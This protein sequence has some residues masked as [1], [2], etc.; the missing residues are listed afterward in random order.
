MV[1]G[2]PPVGRLRVIRCEDV[3]EHGIGLVFEACPEAVEPVL[4]VALDQV[5]VEHEEADQ[6]DQHKHNED[7]ENPGHHNA[8]ASIAA[9]GIGVC[10]GRACRGATLNAGMML[11]IRMS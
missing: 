7:R 9:A 4:H 3:A 11:V 2:V 5:G 10:A 8:S 6:G 1:R